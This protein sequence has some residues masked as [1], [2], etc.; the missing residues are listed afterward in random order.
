VGCV[1]FLALFLTTGIA[2]QRLGPAPA[3]AFDLSKLDLAL[4]HVPADAAF[5][6][7]WMHNREQYDAIVGS[8]A[9]ARLKSLPP[10]QEMIRQGQQQ[11]DRAQQAPDDKQLFELL[12]DM[13]SQEFFI[14]GNENPV[15]LGNLL[16]VL[17]NSAFD[18][19][20]QFNNI[21]GALSISRSYFKTLNENQDLLKIPD[22]VLGFRLTDTKRAED[23][24]KLLEKKI[25]DMGQQQ[26]VPFKVQLKREQAAGMDLLTVTVDGKSVPWPLIVGMAEQRPGEFDGLVKKLSSLQLTISAGIRDG[27]LLVSIG[28]NNAHLAKFGQGPKLI[29]RDEFKRLAPYGE[30]K[31]TSIN[32]VSPSMAA[33]LATGKQDI[34]TWIK[35]AK[36]ALPAGLPPPQRDQLVKDLDQIGVDLKTFVPEP[37]ALLSF[38]FLN[39]RG[40]ESYEFDWGQYPMRDGS[41]PLSLLNHVGGSPLLATVG[42]TKFGAAEYRLVVSWLV[43]LHG[44]FEELVLPNL[45]PEFVQSYRGIWLVVQPALRRIDEATAKMLF[46]GLDGQR[47]FVLDAKITSKQWH[48]LLP[49]SDRPLPMLEPAVLT[50]IN[51]SDLVGR[52]FAEYRAAINELLTKID[53]LTPGMLPP[54]MQ[55]EAPQSR[56]TN[57]GTIYSS[58]LPEMGLDK[59]LTPCVGLSGQVGVLGLSP[60]QAERLLTPTPLAVD[61]GPLANR[62]RP[63]AAAVYVDWAGMVDAAAPWVELLVRLN[64]GE[65]EMKQARTVLEVLK[66]I[67]T[68]SSCTYSESGAWVT[69]SEIV[70]RDLPAAQ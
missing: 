21:N 48:P 5:Y 45:P 16:K 26:Q 18:G 46:P 36:D 61:G 49:P 59:Q 42:R 43:K 63:M 53:Q 7:S 3:P 27:Y 44:Y 37:G 34:D 66:V 25:N 31:L 28:E 1:G 55:I 11:L 29:D 38:S 13:V 40:Q 39:G 58:L 50:G 15:A 20:L 4:K 12:M 10:V 17:N 9:W 14:Y 6:A 69:H 68:Y 19:S 41:R 24:L 22:F 60:A 56:R 70:I 62:D 2:K 30:R 33:G 8:Q 64:A 35:K 23:Q 52:A 67:R 65:E 51:D 47:A 57:N 54:K 32:Y